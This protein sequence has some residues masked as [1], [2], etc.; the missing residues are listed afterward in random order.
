MYQGKPA[1]EFKDQVFSKD[2]AS[3]WE[4]ADA[5]AKVL[6]RAKVHLPLEKEGPECQAC[7]DEQKTMFN[8]QALGA[9]AEQSQAM[10]KHIIPQFIRRYKKDD[11]H[12]TIR[13]MLR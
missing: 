5:K 10:A 4:K 7:H 12:I 8:L 11:E 2:I 6:L 3:Q 9:T 13:E 1:L